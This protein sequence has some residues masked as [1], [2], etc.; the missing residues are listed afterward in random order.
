[1]S[2]IPAIG[3]LPEI[4]QLPHSHYQDSYRHLQLLRGKQP[5]PQSVIRSNNQSENEDTERKFNIL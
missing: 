2:K 5:H 4:H 3:W 1:M